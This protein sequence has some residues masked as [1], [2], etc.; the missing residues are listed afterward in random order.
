MNKRYQDLKVAEGI[1]IPPVTTNYPEDEPYVGLYQPVYDRDFPAVDANYP[2]FDDSFH[3]RWRMFWSYA[4]ILRPLGWMLRLKYGLRWQIEGEK[5]WRRSS[6]GVRRWLRQFDLSR[7]AI[8]VANHCYRH[9]CASVLTSIHASHHTRIPMFAPNFRTKD[10]LFLC[11]VG[12]IPIPAAEEGLSA[13]KAFNSA[14]D[15]YNERGYWF[16]IFP[17][18]KR[19]DWYK[20]L[21][22][23]QKGAFTMAYK[24]NKPI[25]PFAITYRPRTGIFRWFGPANEPLTQV[26]IG[27]PIYPDTT[28]PRAVETERL[29]EL[30][31]ETIC[32]LAG[33]TNNTWPAKPDKE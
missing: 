10:Q 13:M 20:P 22:P 7:G 28:Q 24:Y 32:R 33:I 30:T 4:F 3:N 5:G 6:C 31:H 8:T 16:H 2:Y 1:Y 27:K 21:R 18:A 9:D 12:G 19:W 17:E 23:F 14:F 11:R 25:L 15:Q 29:R 26:I